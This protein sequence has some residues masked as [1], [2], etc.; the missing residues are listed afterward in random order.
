MAKGDSKALT[1]LG[2]KKLKAPAFGRREVFDAKIP[3]LFLRVTSK[4]RKSWG[5]DFRF[6]GKRERLMLGQYPVLELEDARTAGMDALR[7]VRHGINPAAEKRA[8]KARKGDP[9][10]FSATVETFLDRHARRNRSKHETERIFRVY[11]APRWGKR[12][13]KDIG[14]PDVIHLLDHVEDNHGPVMADAVLAQIRK[15]FNWA[16]ERGILDATPIVRGMRRSNPKKRARQRWLRENEI[17]R[18]WFAAEH[19][20]YPFGPFVQMLLITGQRRFEVAAM[21]WD[22]IEGDV[23]T[24]PGSKTKNGQEHEVPLS[25]LA[26]GLL[27][28][29]PQMGDYVFMSGRSLSG[30]PVSGFSKAKARIDEMVSGEDKP[31]QPLEHWTFHDLRRTVRTHMSRI[32][33]SSEIAARVANHTPQGVE[34]VYDRHGYLEEKRGALDRWA[35]VLE[36]ILHPSDDKVVSL[37]GRK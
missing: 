10:Q 31:A 33:I 4:A 3:G 12:S 13:I 30:K 5:L 1:I 20:D 28:Y 16:L 17:K 25:N 24:I 32:G 35:R 22:E 2:V 11:V 18:V 36:T 37:R 9:D 6:Q 27:E 34:A 29:I 19:G 14:R 23:W 26:R 15:L 8:M 7:K 21:R